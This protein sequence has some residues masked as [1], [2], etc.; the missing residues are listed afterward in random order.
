MD[1]RHESAARTRTAVVRVTRRRAAP[2]SALA[3]LRE[4]EER[5]RTLLANLPDRI[6]FKDREGRFLSVNA[7]FAADLGM[8]PGQL[9]GRTDHDLFPADLA[10]KYRADDRRVMAALRPE[11]L[12]ERNV[13]GD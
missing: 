7:L 11:T 8:R 3:A 12:E 4:S 1:T 2:G 9:V 13:V 5:N 6:F 10:D